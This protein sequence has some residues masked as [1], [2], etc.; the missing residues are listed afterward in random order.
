M[1]RNGEKSRAQDQKLKTRNSKILKSQG[2]SRQAKRHECRTN[3][4]TQDDI[5][6][7]GRESLCL[8][9]LQH[10]PEDQD[11]MKGLHKENDQSM[12]I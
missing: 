11:R 2:Q 6:I 10:E 9:A 1:T 12:G 4:K 7:K 8:Q 5:K 3:K